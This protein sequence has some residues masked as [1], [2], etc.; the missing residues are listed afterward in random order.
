M[1]ET[2]LLLR[3]FN[4]T[5]RGRAG[6]INIQHYAQLI[7]D[8][9]KAFVEKLGLNGQRLWVA[10]DERVRFLAELHSG[11]EVMVFCRSQMLVPQGLQF[12]GE[13]RRTTDAKTVCVFPAHPDRLGTGKPNQAERW[14]TASH[15][16]LALSI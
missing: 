1:Q 4:D 14:G 2:P 15:Q 5:H 13:I 8:A 9:S 16:L 10:Q 6:H 11:D 7:A 12:S 3:T